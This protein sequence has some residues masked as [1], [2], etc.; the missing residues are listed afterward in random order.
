MGN[1]SEHG[2]IAAKAHLLRDIASTARAR[3]DEWTVDQMVEMLRLYSSYLGSP[4]SY[5]APETTGPVSFESFVADERLRAT[6]SASPT[7]RVDTP[8]DGD[9]S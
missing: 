1:S 9:A 2:G 6:V 4:S 3:R 8:P 7:R 5:D